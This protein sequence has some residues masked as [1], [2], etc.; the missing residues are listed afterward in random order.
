MPRTL[1]STDVTD[2]NRFTKVPDTSGDVFLK[3]HHNLYLMASDDGG[4]FSH[5]VTCGDGNASGLLPVLW[6]RK[7][8]SVPFMGCIWV[9]LVPLMPMV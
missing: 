4:L 6:E 3:T 1:L 8:L 7:F 5:L 9:S 2:K